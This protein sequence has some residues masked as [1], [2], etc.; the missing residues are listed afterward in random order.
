MR[1]RGITATGGR[2]EPLE[3]GAG[4]GRVR[5]SGHRTMARLVLPF[6]FLLGPAA[7]A[8]PPKASKKAASAAG[9]RASAV[10]SDTASHEANAPLPPDGDLDGTAATA[11][12]V[13]AKETPEPSR[14]APSTGASVAATSEA[15]TKREARADEARNDDSSSPRA[16]DLAR[17]RADYDRL[18]DEL[19]RARVRS[20]Q[21]ETNIYHARFDATLIWKGRP[22]FVLAKARVLLDGAEL[23]DSGDRTESDDRVQVAERPVKPGP[24]ALTVRMEIRPRAEQK[25]GTKTGHDRLGYTSEHTFAITVPD[26]KRTHATLTADED[27]DPPSYEPELELE[28][29]SEP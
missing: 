13:A 19:F 9:P 29:G 28:L 3:H 27:G 23:W 16:A 2:A 7:E 18:R 11:K 12:L 22:D 4:W 20:Q 17:L 8:R 24:H 21:V 10:H 6:L 26:N 14:A 1:R 5:V 15:A 25:G